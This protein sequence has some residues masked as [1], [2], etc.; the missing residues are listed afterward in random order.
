M[1]SD[2]QLARQMAALKIGKSGAAPAASST[3]RPAGHARTAS[4]TETAKLLT[5]MAPPNL[6]TRVAGAN[7]AMPLASARTVAAAA[8]S[9]AAAAPAAPARAAAPSA[10]RRVPS[11]TAFKPSSKIA[12]SASSSNLK[13][14]AAVPAMTTKPAATDA[15]P[16]MTARAAATSTKKGKEVK[17]EGIGKYDGALEE[18]DAG[19]VVEGESADD[20]ALDSSTVECAPYFAILIFIVLIPHLE[21]ARPRHGTCPTLR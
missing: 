5:K 11:Q 3:A 21:P 15:A 10:V 19:G 17:I 12:P 18:E 16:V 6:P 13:A 2:A 7:K 8:P 20:L 4:A 14:A 1:S 9:T